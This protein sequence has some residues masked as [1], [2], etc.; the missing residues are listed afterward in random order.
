M[1]ERQNETQNES[2]DRTA[3]IIEL[4]FRGMILP[5]PFIF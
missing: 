2:N 5:P 4:M 1:E 3:T